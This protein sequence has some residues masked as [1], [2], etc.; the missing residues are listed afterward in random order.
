MA[1]RV[2]MELQQWTLAEHSMQAVLAIAPNHVETHITLA[3][4]LAK[5]VSI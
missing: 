5:N 3:Q 1:A 2:Y 4:L